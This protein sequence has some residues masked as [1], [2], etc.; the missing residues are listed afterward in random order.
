M[1]I[2]ACKSLIGLPF[3]SNFIWDE[4]IKIYSNVKNKSEVINN[5]IQKRTTNA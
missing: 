5:P 4:A 3:A 2:I 1:Y